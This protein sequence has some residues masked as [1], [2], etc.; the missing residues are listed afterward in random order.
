MNILLAWEDTE[1]LDLLSMYLGAGDNQITVAESQEHF[2]SVLSNGTALDVVLLS[3]RYPDLEIAFDLF[4]SVRKIRPEVPI[5]CGCKPDDI[6][7]LA[8]YMMDG[9]KSYILRDPNGDF[10]FLMNAMLESVVESVRAERE[11][12]LAEKLREEVESVRKLQET[13]IPKN[14]K[15]PHGYRVCAR[16][17]PS[18]VKVLGG[19]AVTM[20]GGDYYDLFGLK[21]NRFVVLVGDASGHGMKACMSVITMHTLVRMLKDDEHLDPADFVTTVNRN[22]CEQT[23][24]SADGG[25]ITLAYGILNGDS[26]EFKWCSAG[27]PPPLIQSLETGEITPVANEDVGGMPLGLFEGAEYEQ[28]VF[29]IPPKSR[30][31]LFTD[32]LAEAF[33]D[34]ANKHVEFGIAG[35]S[36]TLRKT[37]TQPIEQTLQALF[38]DSNAFTQGNGRHDDTSVVIIER[39][40]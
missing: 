18:Q 39:F 17:E 35:I 29:K 24:V 5:V 38:D 10:L 2:T 3:T 32:G 9:M 31:L 25:F 15:P 36:D 16:Y 19:Q 33:P 4:R 14:I 8:R 30:L 12:K 22:L 7:R 23:V 6:Y 28:H 21:G 40:E 37:S 13:I 11:Q 1:Q 26:G 27:H 20:A 34:N